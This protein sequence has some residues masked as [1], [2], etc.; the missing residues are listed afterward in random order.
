[1]NVRKMALE[2]IR[3]AHFASREVLMDEEERKERFRK[4]IKAV[5]ISHVE[6]EDVGIVFKLDTGEMI[7]TYCNLIDFAD[8][9]VMLKGGTVIPL[10]SIV[11]IEF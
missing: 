5:I 4:L 7:E 9:Y 10:T 1:M 11:D 8:D 3:T 2:E 6:H